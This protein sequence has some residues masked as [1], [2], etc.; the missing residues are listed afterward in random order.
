L[1]PNLVIIDF[2]EK[3]ER[4]KENP[5]EDLLNY[6][7]ASYAELLKQTIDKINVRGFSKVEK[8]NAFLQSMVILGS[9]L[10]YFG[11]TE[12]WFASFTE[13]DRHNL[14][15]FIV[16]NMSGED[17]WT[18]NHYKNI[19]AP[20]PYESR[21]FFETVF[22]GNAYGQKIFS[23]LMKVSANWQGLV[24]YLS[25][26]ESFQTSRGFQM[27]SF[28]R[29]LGLVGSHTYPEGPLRE[30]YR[31]RLI[32]G[33]S[34]YADSKALVAQKDENGIP[35]FSY[36]PHLKK[37]DVSEAE[38]AWALEVQNAKSPH[39]K[40]YQKILFDSLVKI[41]STSDH[42]KMIRVE[43]GLAL[44]DLEIETLSSAK[45]EK[46]FQ[47]YEK[48]VQS[49]LNPIPT[50][51]FLDSGVLVNE[52]VEFLISAMDSASGNRQKVLDYIRFMLASQEPTYKTEIEKLPPQSRELMG[53]ILS[54]LSKEEIWYLSETLSPLEQSVRKE[55][56]ELENKYHLTGTKPI[57][58]T[59]LDVKPPVP[60]DE[61]KNIRKNIYTW[62]NVLP[63]NSNV[64]LNL[65]SIFENYFPAGPHVLMEFDFSEL[66]RL[67]NN[68]ETASHFNQRGNE[69]AT[70]FDAPQD[71]A[72]T[73]FGIYYRN[74]DRIT[75]PTELLTTY[76]RVIKL[77]G[78]AFI[79]TLEQET[80][81]REVFM[82]KLTKLTLP[83]QMKWLE[84]PS[85]RKA[86]GAEF[87]GKQMALYVSKGAG[88][89]RKKLK[90]Y[91]DRILAKLQ[92]Q[93]EWPDAYQVY[94]DH[95]AEAQKVQ[96]HELTTLFPEDSRTVTEKVD[97][98]VNLIRGMSA[99]STY[100]RS[101][102]VEEQIQ[103]IEFM[104]GRSGKM[105]QSLE[106]AKPLKSAD[107][108]VD[109]KQ[110]FLEMREELKFRTLLERSMVV[111]SILAGPNSL[112]A[113]PE[114]LQKI[115]DHLLKAVSADK[116]EVAAIILKALS[117]AEGRNYSLILSY[118]LSQKLE[119]PGTESG[120]NEGLV[121]R[122]L[123]DSYGVPGVKLAQYLAFTN[124]FKDLQSALES[125]QDAAMPISYY[126]AL[127]LLQKRLGAAW[128]PAKYQVL[129][130]IGTGSVNVAI[131]YLN[132][133]TAKSE[134]VTIARDEIEVKTKE[135]FRRFQLLVRELTR[136]PDLQKRFGFV[137]DLM[138]L[139]ERSVALEF[140]KA[141]SFKMQKLVQE[142]YNRKVGNWNIRT[143][144]AY[145]VSGM[146]IWM[147]KAQGKGARKILKT[148]PATYE[149]AMRAFMQ[150]EYG[151]LRGVNQTG[152]WLPLALE[153][154]PD[155][156]D[157]QIMIDVPTNTVTVLD[158]GQAVEISNQEREFALD[159][160]AIISKAESL[161]S[162][163]RIVQKYSQSIQN[164]KVKLNRDELA[165]I[166]K[167]DERMDIFVHLLAQ[168]Q[169]AG[170]EVPLPTVHWVL[171]ANRLVKLGE[172]VRLS[173]ESSL[174]W[175]IG[176][177]KVGLPLAVFNAG[178]DLEE[179]AIQEMKVLHK[180]LPFAP[181]CSEIFVKEALV[182]P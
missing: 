46:L 73:L 18:V 92:I 180:H 149:S 158:F 163:E 129:G 7:D 81:L 33:L 105:P 95:V 110:F 138:S 74:L 144:D 166:L 146:A 51:G 168:L 172:K 8:M 169:R 78:A 107:K 88:A 164:R 136:T 79:P 64:Q 61:Y 126:E 108:F 159:L 123:L 142:L 31:S 93:Q 48:N 182:H 44:R 1:D 114:G 160:L 155:I 134:V 127:L 40:A 86:L 19:M 22:L 52:E 98:G 150:V 30:F 91:S 179:K 94:R 130:I 162:I 39:M 111:N 75:D 128:D 59:L 11:E 50:Q 106:T 72:K 147:E 13:K 157:G 124:A 152:N 148:D 173:P 24:N 28:A 16:R 70:M 57:L 34:S 54:T 132:L 170:F 90:R 62:M 37:E 104:M 5:Y 178:K 125:Y 69:L 15:E 113:K 27:D 17:G 58:R 135:D 85:L 36:L 115:N 112:L 45:K 55:I 153:A 56:T 131:E 38:K 47:A 133:A 103:M 89:D 32:K 20:L 26:I 116:R 156:H 41:F 60:P 14:E 87:V 122:A 102:P 161:D 145:S 6:T 121:L 151:I 67:L 117:A 137:G 12:N 167:S 21:N 119:N 97:K 63:L 154:N 101:L 171:A 35:T 53:K 77:A 23:R 96:P 80:H 65:L 43:A 174:K 49:F 4:R 9:N 176:M 109:I 118:A 141:H 3:L 175:L 99:F 177:R 84:T 71:A 100:T 42:L 143:I 181:R 10:K 82:N 25:S 165:K 140:D 29:L 68:I 66:K 139:I 120:L 76:D 2:S 83:Q